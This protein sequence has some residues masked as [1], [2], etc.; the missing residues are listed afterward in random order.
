[1]KAQDEQKN[2]PPAATAPAAAPTPVNPSAATETPAA[3]PAQTPAPAATAPAAAP[4]E[5]VPLSKMTVVGTKQ[6]RPTRK[7][8]ATAPVSAPPTPAPGAPTPAQ[9]ALDRKMHTLDQ[10]REN[11]LPKL[12]A[13][14]YTITREAI[15]ALPQADNTP[16]DKLILQMPG[17][18]YDSA[19]S[20]PSFH[21]RNE[22]ANVQIRINGVLLPEGVS[23]LGPYLDTNFIGSISLLSGTLPAQY[24]L[25]TAGVLDITSRSFS[26]PA[27]SVS[28]YGGSRETITPSFDYGGSVGNTQYFVTGRGNWNSLGL[29]N[30]TPFLNADHDYTQQGKFFGFASTL[31]D[32]STRFSVMSGYAYSAFQIPNNPGQTPL[33]DFGPTTYSS[34]N[35]NENEYDTYAFQLAALQTKG[36]CIDTQFAVFLRYANVHFVPDIFGDLV[37]NDVASDVTRQS[38]LYGTQFDAAYELNSGNKLR[39]GFA[40]TAE[41]TNVINVSTV[42]PVDPNTGA[43]SPTPFPIT[44]ANSLLGWD[45][46]TYVQDEIKLTDRLT[47]NLGIR[48]DQLYQFVDA[49][50]F[51][52]RAVIVFKPDDGTTIHAGYARYFTPPMQAQAT[53]SN[54]ALFNNTTNQ[55]EVPL[56]DPVLPERSHYFDVGVDRKVLPGLDVGAD[57]FYKIATDMIDDGQ[58]GQAVV[59]TQFNWAQGYS[60]G[61]EFKLKYQEG[62]FKAYANFSYII[63]K[64]ID[65]VSNQYLLDAA[66]YTYLLSAY[67]YTDDMQWMTGSAGASY[68]WDKVLFTTSMIYGSGLRSGFANI[69]H[70]TPYASVNVGVAREFQLMPSDK[71]LTVRFDIV[72]LFDQVYELRTGT[73]IG[74]FAPQYGARRGYFL[75]LSQ[76]L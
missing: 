52:P 62:N 21:V 13:T 25:R 3:P 35:V 40:V 44:D 6:V 41:K 10:G 56:A 8:A 57:V 67:H 58:F 27:G 39:F 16:I 50:Q 48:F 38:Y 65:A 70:A 34:L 46:G 20:N 71:P 37:F 19:V 30:P 61:A 29:E 32:D 74:E 72:N 15:E 64:A 18:S 23:A 68:R 59:L 54:L 7:P 42:L 17:V 60:E 26:A 33:G 9:E 5:A 51:S 43:I 63:T 11:I 36:D 4:A 22:Y 66:T 47:L 69:D 2:P 24:G 12:G 49:N 45:I 28:I 76:K 53:Q 55:P 1:M 73:G 14:T 75:G 31:L